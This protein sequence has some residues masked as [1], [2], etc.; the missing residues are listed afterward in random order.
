[1]TDS[2]HTPDVPMS[3]HTRVLVPLLAALIGLTAIPVR[4]QERPFIFSVA[5][6]TERDAKQIRIDY[7]VGAGE[8]AFQS[9][10]SNQPEQRLGVQA[11]VG[12]VTFLARFGVAQTGSAY[13]SSQ[14][15]EVLV[16]LIAGSARHLALAVG[17]GIQHEAVG[18]D[19]LLARVLA[20][21]ELPEWRAHAN[22]VL[23]KPLAAG[24]DTVDLATTA[25]WARKLT[26]GVAFGLEAIGEDLEG[27]WDRSEAEGGARLLI[28]P[29]FHLMPVGRPWQLTAAGG[30]MLHPSLTGRSSDALRDLPSTTRQWG[31]AARASLS[32]SL[33]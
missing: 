27:F 14:A 28:G 25:G 24:R 32:V 19:V 6:T 5:T 9:D 10:T 2:A 1:M 4:A 17:G 16:S 26:S 11:S 12:R 20:A 30:P 3:L 22:V 13:Q 15:G 18:T 33:F 8:R 21:R 31:Y 7:E 23:Q 29:S